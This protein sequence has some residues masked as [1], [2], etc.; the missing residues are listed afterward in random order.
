MAEQYQSLQQQQQQQHEKP[1]DQVS[2]SGSP[3]NVVR[4]PPNVPHSTSAWTPIASNANLK[5]A[6]A[7]QS[8]SP[9]SSGGTAPDLCEA[10]LGR[11]DYMHNSGMLG[12]S[13]EVSPQLHT[14]H[15]E[16]SSSRNVSPAPIPKPQV[17]TLPTHAVL[18]PAVTNQSRSTSTDEPA[19]PSTQ[20]ASPNVYVSNSGPRSP[21]A[22]VSSGDHTWYKRQRQPTMYSKQDK[23]VVS[24]EIVCLPHQYLRDQVSLSL[25]IQHA[26]KH[27]KFAT[28]SQLIL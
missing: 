9:A 4:I 26:F 16:L 19:S 27:L 13:R 11:R 22:A 5:L 10:E 3:I 28:N 21:R 17:S 8:S 15:T 12:R 24:K 18:S 2:S 14:P 6:L 1:M 20:G 7:S 23:T 25:L